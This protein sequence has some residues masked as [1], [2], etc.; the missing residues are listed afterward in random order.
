METTS[1]QPKADI[2][3]VDDT[4]E[5]L[6][7]LSQILTMYGYKARAVPDGML[8]ISVA[9]S[10]PPD[11]ILM[12]INMPGMDGFE[13]CKRLK[14]DERTQHI[15]V[16]FL[17]AM[18]EVEDK[19]KGFDAGGVDYITKPFQVDEVLARLET[20]L[21]ICRLQSLLE[22]ANNE[23][24][25]RLF[26][27]SQAQ[28]E[29]RMQRVLAE[30][31]VETVSAI[32]LS[33]DYNE[34]LDLILNNMAKVVPHDASNIALLDEQNMVRVH[35]FRGYQEHGSDHYQRSL[36]VPLDHHQ[37]WKKAY[38][39]HCPVVVDDTHTMSSS[40]QIPQWKPIPELKWVR[41]HACVPILSKDKVMGF[42]NLDSEIPYFFTQE[43][44]ERMKIFADQRRWSD[45]GFQPAVPI[46][47][48]STGV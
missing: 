11:L 38:D 10:T 48:G 14:A 29:E 41:S 31:L 17:S 36:Y 8:A 19:V 7:V 27:L 46:G 22:D 28:I 6:R 16:I 3:L 21:S 5:N 26:E 37:V 25:E 35:R 30:T 12:D 33:L 4:P 45:R 43:H 20:H 42:L 9:Q 23:L 47:T 40:D 2:L 24:A 34:V 18:S 13:T 44:V 1:I 39:C 15:P 32:N